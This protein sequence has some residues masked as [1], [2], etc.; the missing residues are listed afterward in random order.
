MAFLVI[1]SGVACAKPDPVVR[2]VTLPVPVNPAP[3]ALPPRP[4]LPAQNIGMAKTPDD[5]ERLLI[6]TIEVL[7]RWSEILEERIQKHNEQTK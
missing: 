3:I 6:A 4:A 1:L 2:T 7:I 5:R